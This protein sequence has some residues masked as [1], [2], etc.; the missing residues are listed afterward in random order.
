MAHTLEITACAAR[1]M[2]MRE[3]RS[4]KRH[5]GDHRE[6]DQSELHSPTVQEIAEFLDVEMSPRSKM[7]LPA[8]PAAASAAAAAQVAA[9]T[10]AG[11]SNKH[12]VESQTGQDSIDDG[13]RYR[14]SST[15]LASPLMT[16]LVASLL[17]YS[18]ASLV[19]ASGAEYTSGCHAMGT[20]LQLPI[21]PVLSGPRMAYR[22]MLC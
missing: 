9:V 17:K 21:S 5:R 14:R 15:T 10:E 1:L 19:C 6:L 16:P 7:G 2:S 22:R 12:V 3:E 13:Y 20:I 4:G 18:F 8:M 11:D